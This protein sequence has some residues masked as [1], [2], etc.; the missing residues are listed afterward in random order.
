MELLF[1]ESLRSRHPGAAGW[2]DLLFTHVIALPY[3]ERALEQRAVIE[4][5]ER[6]RW[7][8]ARK[9]PDG[10][11]RMVLTFDRDPGQLVVDVAPDGTIKPSPRF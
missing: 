7:E 11:I 9:L 3:K 5:L 10:S 6:A 4:I 8:R 2:R 1:I